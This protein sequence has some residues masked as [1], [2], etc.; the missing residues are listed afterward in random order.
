MT[1]KL[2]FHKNNVFNYFHLH[3]FDSVLVF[4][5]NC[6]YLTYTIIKMNTIVLDILI[7]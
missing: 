2:Q 1:T 5:N 7:F 6:H 3:D 4:I